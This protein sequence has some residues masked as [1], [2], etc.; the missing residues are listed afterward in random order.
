MTA[1]TLTSQKIITAAKELVCADTALTFANLGR[2]LGT[3]SQAI[4]PYYSD[5]AAVHIA[6]ANDF[7]QRLVSQLQQDLVGLAGE[8]AISQ[9]AKTC[10]QLAAA[11]FP[12]V[13]LILNM[14]VATK[15][16]GTLKESIDQVYHVLERLLAPF[17]QDEAHQLVVSRMIRNLI[18][19]EIVHEGTGRFQNPAVSAES[20]FN[21]M[22]A[23]AL[24]SFD[25]QSG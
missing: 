15:R 3:K 23:L 24:T 9:F 8:P 5:V 6:I 20:S 14:P 17:N 1:R 2:H 19:G 10:R 16:V 11:E 4:Y 18:I 22:L 13:Q 25:T 12:I 7:F 21:Q